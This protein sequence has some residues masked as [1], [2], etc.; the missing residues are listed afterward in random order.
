MKWFKRPPT[1]P[2]FPPRY[3][4]DDPVHVLLLDEV[5][6]EYAAL[7]AD[8]SHGYAKCMYRPAELLPYPR[9]EIRKAVEAML[10]YAEGR[11]SSRLLEPKAQCEELAQHLRTCLA[12]LDDYLE[13]PPEQLPRDALENARVGAQLRRVR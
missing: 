8:E 1:R 13:V 11:K 7:L 5:V 9:G 12:Y 2:P 3:N 6:Q 4:L 10:A